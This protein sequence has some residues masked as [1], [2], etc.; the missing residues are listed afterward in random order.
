[1]LVLR[2]K[3]DR[4]S[5]FA[6]KKAGTVCLIGSWHTLRCSYDVTYF[7]HAH[8]WPICYSYAYGPGL[9]LSFPVD[10]YHSNT[11]KHFIVQH[12]QRC[13]PFLYIS[14]RF[15][16]LCLA[17]CLGFDEENKMASGPMKLGKKRKTVPLRT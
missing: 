13:T 2:I 16:T 3:R 8:V 5:L 15:R 9:G 11:Q 4:G 10:F 17:R 12:N 1:M 7:V 14:A 6:F